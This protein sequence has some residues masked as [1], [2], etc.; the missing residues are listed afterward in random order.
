VIELNELASGTYHV[1]WWD[2]H[3]GKI[4]SHNNHSTTTGTLRLSVPAFNNDIACKVV[5]T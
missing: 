2:T 1:Q 3:Q 5:G 4:I